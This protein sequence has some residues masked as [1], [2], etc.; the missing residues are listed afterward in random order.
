MPIY[1]YECVKCGHVFEKLQKVGE[2]SENLT[3][4]ECMAK[5]PRKLVTPFRTNFWSSFLDDM[6]RKVSPHKFK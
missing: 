2:G 3:C 5:N 6:D 4:P 1:E